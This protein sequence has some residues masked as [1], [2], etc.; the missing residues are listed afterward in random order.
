MTGQGAKFL[1]PAA[2][3]QEI[4]VWRLLQQNAEAAGRDAMKRPDAL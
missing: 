3:W 4:T 1:L 2:V